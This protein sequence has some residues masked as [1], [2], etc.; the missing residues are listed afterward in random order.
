MPRFIPGIHI[1]LLE[2][3]CT[4]AADGRDKP[5]HH[6]HLH[7]QQ[8]VDPPRVFAEAFRCVFMSSV[9]GCGRSTVKL[10]AM[11]AGPAVSTITRVPRNTASVMPCVTNT[12]VFLALLPDAQEFEVHLLAR[13]RIERAERLVHQDQLR[14]VH[15][16]TR[17]G[18]ALL[19]A[20]RQLVG[21]LVL[22]SPSARRGRAGR[23]RAR[24]SPPSAARGFRREAG[25]CRSR[26][27]T[28][29][30]MAAGTPCRCR[31]RDRTRCDALPMRTSPESSGCRPA[32]IFSSVVLPQPE[33]PTSATSSPAR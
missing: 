9:R 16:R 13:Q 31:A 24:G 8:A 32:R 3:R 25:R 20:A 7:A 2:A 17:D 5:G 22:G 29:A 4:V 27:A 19:H 28:S 15:Q 33:G 30:T 1:L 11:R 23:G 18:R 26:D 6:G 21:V 12:M 10:S 14:I